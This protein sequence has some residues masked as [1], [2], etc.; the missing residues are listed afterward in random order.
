MLYERAQNLQKLQLHETPR[1]KLPSLSLFSITAAEDH[2][3]DISL[4]RGVI[5][6]RPGMIFISL[7]DDNTGQAVGS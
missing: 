1:R 5:L 7:A 3:I 6:A 2:L 4:A